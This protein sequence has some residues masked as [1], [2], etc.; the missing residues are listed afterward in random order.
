MA[1]EIF[2]VVDAEDRVIGQAPR[3]E[4][5]ARGMLHR[6]VH[7]L[8]FNTRGELLVQRRSASKDEFPLCFTTSASGHVSAG[9]SYE[10]S[11]PREL[12]EE[13]GLRGPLE[14]LAKFPASPETANEHSVV[15]RTVTDDVPV[16]DPVEIESG[17]YYRL[18]EL[19][20]MSSAEP[21]KFSPPFRLLLQWYVETFG[22]PD[23][24][25][26]LR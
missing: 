16:F 14:F 20:E 18:D 15:Y 2:D 24:R 22:M 26:R 25:D 7:I 13:L 19:L 10:E 6:A 4:V 1:E 3:S 8:V 11:A 12:E 23:Y 17:G 21:E 9:E 5:H